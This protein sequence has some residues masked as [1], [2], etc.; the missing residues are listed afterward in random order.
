M[1]INVL[2]NCSLAVTSEKRWVCEGAQVQMTR[3]PSIRLKIPQV[4]TYVTRLPIPSSPS[5]T[6]LSFVNQSST[7]TNDRRSSSI[8]N[9]AWSTSPQPLPRGG[10][11]DVA[12]VGTAEPD[13]GERTAPSVGDGGSPRRRLS[14]IRSTLS[15]SQ[16]LG[17]GDRRRPT[18]VAVNSNPA[19]MLRNGNGD[20][21]QKDGPAPVSS[22]DR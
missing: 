17:S 7:T 5:R 10:P 13:G 19:L 15:C 12:A 9:S 6:S 4:V 20:D 21:Q 18:L 11:D 14:G 1:Y 16:L 22:R 2:A 8:V 3:P